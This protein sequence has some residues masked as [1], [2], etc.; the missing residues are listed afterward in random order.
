MKRGRYKAIVSSDWNQCLAPCKPFDPIAFNYPDLRSDLTLIF[1]EYTGNKIS[2]GSA[3]KRI[4][5]LLPQPLSTQQMDAY[6]DEKYSTYTGVPE[7]IDWCMKN[8]ILFMINTT[9]FMGYFQRIFARRLLPEIPVLSANPLVQYPSQETDPQQIYA[10][11][12]IEDKGKNSAHVLQS[13][14][15]SEKKIV[16][17]GDSGGDGPHFEWGRKHKAYI[18][19]SMA[20]KSLLDYCHKKNIA[21]NLF[22][23]PSYTASKEKINENEMLTDFM[24]L[25]TV[26]EKIID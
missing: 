2:F 23:G 22:F 25:K 15:F 5:K 10:L 20:K 4:K 6:L 21:I 12:E 11:N 18:I 8:Q 7:L 26:F 24:E 19:G 13:Y 1:K 14:S 16:L 17:L 9:G 3:N